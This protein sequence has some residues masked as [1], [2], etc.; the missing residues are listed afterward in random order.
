MTRSIASPVAMS[1]SR[2]WALTSTPPR[3]ADV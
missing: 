1:F 3:R 2:G